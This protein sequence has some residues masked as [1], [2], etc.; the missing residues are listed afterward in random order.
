MGYIYRHIRLDTNEVFYIGVG[1]LLSDDNHRRANK[2]Y[3]RSNFWKNII[4]KTEYEVEIILDNMSYE[5]TLK[6]EI[7]FI[8][9]Y[10]RLNN[11][12]GTLV[13]LTDGGEG[14]NGMKHS[15]QT[16][17]NHSDRMKGENHP[18]YGI[19]VNEQRKEQCRNKLI[20]RTNEKHSS[21]MKHNKNSCK[22]VIDIKTNII[23]TSITEA[24]VAVGIKRV[25]LNAM[26]KGY[27]PNKTSL[28]YINR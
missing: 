7:E 10:G 12:T 2:K 24:S 5:D 1:G 6:K 18:M 3:G 8:K 19:K 14:C 4:N 21:Y 13:N 11:G 23:Y 26:L 15:N 22:Q 28:K 20:G 9:I 17:N 27:N 25:T 16:K